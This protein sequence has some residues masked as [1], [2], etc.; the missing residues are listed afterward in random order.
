M[1]TM[2]DET[3]ISDDKE[4]AFTTPT[5]KKKAEKHLLPIELR[6][7]TYADRQYMVCGMD[8]DTSK[9]NSENYFEVAQKIEGYGDENYSIVLN[10]LTV[11]GLRQLSKQF[12]IRNVGS[13]TKFEIQML[14]AAR[15]NSTDKYNI[16]G[17]GSSKVT[18]A[19]NTKIIVRIVNAVFHPDNFEAFL[20]LNDRKG[21][22]AFETGLGANNNKFGSIIADFVNDVSNIDL[23]KFL[24]INATK[25]LDYHNHVLTAE[26]MGFLPIRCSQ[27]T[28]DS[29]QASIEKS[30]QQFFL[31]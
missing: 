9:G 23:D 8:N 24:I 5:L 11:L 28:G 7:F 19:D 17:L 12:K 13:Q 31:I 16:D 22:N 25:N 26:D 3:G 15:K 20:S 30:G 21:R 6:N 18:S 4:V 1:L 10:N 27:Q 29:C 14:L 2:D